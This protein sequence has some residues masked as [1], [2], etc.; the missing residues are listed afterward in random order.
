MPKPQV[1]PSAAALKKRPEQTSLGTDNLLSLFEAAVGPAALA[2]SLWGLAFHFE[3]EVLP[4]Y[5]ILSVIVFALT[6]PGKS[7]L[8]SSIFALLIDIAVNWITVAGLLLATG[9]AT[10]YLSEFSHKALTT[11][12]WV[13][14]LAELGACLMLRG[15]AQSLL[16][17]HGP[18]QRAIIVGMNEQGV[19]LAT[20]ISES[21]YSRVEFIGFVDSRKTPRLQSGSIHPELGSLDQLA[22]L[23]QA[24]QVQIIYLSLPMAS[25]PRILHILDELKD[26]T[27]S[28]Y[29]VPDMFVTDLIQ[30]HSGSVN[31]MPVIS[32]CE[33]PFKGTNG[34]VKRLGDIVFSL[35]IL[36]LIFPLLLV[37]A[38]AVKLGSPGPIIFKQR[39]YGLDGGEILVYKFRSMSVTEDG[40][41]IKQAQKNDKRVTRL[42][43]F[44]RRSSLDELP[45]FINVLQGRMSIVGPRPHAV[46]HNELYRKLIK[47]Y[48]VRHKV[49]PGITG[50]AQVNG[51]R[52]ETETLD[53]MQGRIDFDLDYLRNWSLRLDVHI[54][55]KTIL[56]VLKDQKAY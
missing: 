48:M 36:T 21:V 29:F 16:K 17:L 9:F 54:I 12:L 22:N 6:Y 32:V 8:Q 2:F 24:Y 31:G 50:W 49:K 3:G 55:L 26:T 23:V 45:Q 18:R 56:L 39:R 1:P 42:G 41:A 37:I 7:Q 15:A 28:I 30:G 4:S 43:A 47:G 19:A 11:W 53:K 10:G 5:L 27:A 13:A 35:L 40:G 46:A 52:G 51:Y 25:Q 38:A 14:P 44:L 33:T 20:K 34:V